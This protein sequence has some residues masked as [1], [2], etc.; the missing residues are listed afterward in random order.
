M[1]GGN[2]P[3][4]RGCPS[5]SAGGGLRPPEIPWDPMEFLARSWSISAMEVSKK[6]AS[7][8]KLS[9]L[10]PAGSYR[11][12]RT[13]WQRRAPW[14]PQR[15][16][17]PSPLPSSSWKGSWRRGLFD[18]FRGFVFLWPSKVAHQ[19]ASPMTS[20]RLSHSSDA[21]SGSHSGGS[22]SE[23][24]P[25]FSS[26]ADDAVKLPAA[27]P[28]AIFQAAVAEGRQDRGSVA[29]GPPERKKEETRTHNA[30]LHA[31][32]SVAGVASA[33]AAMAAATPARRRLGAPRRTTRRRRW[34]W[35]SPPPPPSSLRTAWRRRSPSAP[36]RE[37]SVSVVASAVNLWN[38]AAV[39][40]LEKG[41]C[42]AWP[43]QHHLSRTA[44]TTGVN[45]A[46]R[47]IAGNDIPFSGEL[48]AEDSSHVPF[49]WKI[50]L[51]TYQ[52]N[53]K[54]K[55]S[56]AAAHHKKKKWDLPAWPGR[57]FAG[58][59]ASS[60]PIT[61]GSEDAEPGLSSSSAG[62]QRDYEIWTQGVAASL[63]CTAPAGAPH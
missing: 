19:E 52:Q 21:L 10:S 36:S 53:G 2:S 5:P 25:V 39:V 18:A 26:L 54:M 47:R 61:S 37:L 56:Y 44:L 58:R 15:T 35:R 3:L 17:S 28:P 23:G 48:A 22:L 20:G 46:G 57:A 49:H 13:Q 27:A 1:E 40:P 31:A 6:L 30:Q 9:T 45:P 43:P 24:T 51:S 14:P 62:C 41:E 8:K 60:P 4:P 7:P 12:K 38:V 59:G 33:V 32:V 29:E 11:R 63:T 55:S 50:V 16:L 42:R 34:T